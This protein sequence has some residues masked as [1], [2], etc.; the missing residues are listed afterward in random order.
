MHF[1]D[2][3]PEWEDDEDFFKNYSERLRDTRNFYT[4]GANKNKNKK[5]LETTK[6]LVTASS[7]FE[8]VMYYYVL[9][10]IYGEEN[11]RLILQ[12]PYLMNKIK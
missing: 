3:D 1:L 4:H 12:L 10:S 11:D 6:D 2:I 7:I 5:R 8:C 9:K